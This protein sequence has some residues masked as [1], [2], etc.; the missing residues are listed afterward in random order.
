M[1]P[2]SPATGRFHARVRPDRAGRPGPR[3]RRGAPSPRDRPTAPPVRPPPATSGPPRTSRR[4]A[5]RHGRQSPSGPVPTAS[6]DV[7]GPSAAVP[8]ARTRRSRTVTGP[9]HRHPARRCCRSAA[10]CARP[11]RRRSPRPRCTAPGRRRPSPPAGSRRWRARHR[12]AGRVRLYGPAVRPQQGQDGA[13]GLAGGVAVVR[14]SPGQTALGEHTRLSFHSFGCGEFG[15]ASGG[16]V[17]VG[18]RT[19]IATGIATGISTQIGT[20]FGGRAR[21]GDRVRAPGRDR[22]RTRARRGGRPRTDRNISIRMCSTRGVIGRRPIGFGRTGGR[23]RQRQRDGERD[24][25]RQRD[26]A[27][28]RRTLHGTTWI[29]QGEEV[30]RRIDGAPNI[31]ARNG[32]IPGPYPRIPANT[33][34][35]TPVRVN[36][37]RVL[38]PRGA[39]GG[40]IREEGVSEARGYPRRG[41]IRGEGGGGSGRARPGRRFRERAGRASAWVDRSGTRVRSIRYARQYAGRSARQ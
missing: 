6:D 23:G 19:G 29:C 2:P 40:G 16:A 24:R 9:N 36:R 38:C 41:G 12:P 18:C 1:H 30:D 15:A 3:H 26:H 32:H 35:L 34:Q 5:H 27:E 4:P 22:C 8:P 10:A 20:G 31:S 28:I 13:Q 39:V 33:G 25:A 37:P 11:A 7:S 21:T 17:A 14:T